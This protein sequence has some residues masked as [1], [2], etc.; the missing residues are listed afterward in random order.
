MLLAG[1]LIA[2][3]CD[4]GPPEFAVKAVAAG[5]PSL[6]PF[7]EEDGQLGED[8]TIASQPPHSGLQQGN[9]PGLYGG[10]GKP[11]ICDVERLKEFLTNP[12][13]DQKARE[14]ARIVGIKPARKDRIEEYL[15]GLTPVFLRHDT[16]VVNHD[17]KKGR[18]VAFDALLEAG[19]AVLV[20]DKGMPAVKCS[21]GN[22][23]RP[24]DKN[25]EHIAVEFD[26]GN[27]K[28]DGFDESDVVTVRPAPQTLDRV[29]LVD[30]HD[31][32]RGITRPVGSDGEQ[33]SSFDATEEHK[34]PSVTG[35]S[36]G[37]A[38]QKLAGLGLAVAYSGDELPPADA[39]VTGSEPGPGTELRFGEAVTL[40]VR[41]VGDGKPSRG[42]RT[43]PSPSEDSPAGSPTDSPT[44]EPT[45]REPTTREP[46]TSEPTTDE[47]TTSEPTSQEPTTS[48]PTTNRPTTTE[49]TTD[50]P[51]SAAPSTTEPSTTKPTTTEPTTTEPST[52]KPGTTEPTTTE[53]VTRE[54][55]P[56]EP[57]S[58]APVTKEP[59]PSEPASSAP[60]SSGDPPPE[61]AVQSPSPA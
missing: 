15:D 51:T 48:E 37:A 25:P 44:G 24:F 47:P 27:T 40:E 7:F 29:V 23:L 58:S 11:R 50:E 26:D 21:C 55:P 18:A 45:T 28:W 12:K 14:W 46:T 59:P 6:A 20:D 36:F 19:I 35:M 16:L 13:N 4:S 52:T 30:V 10:S 33:D 8:A 54:P 5:I 9:A 53:P 17:Y 38:G 3:G 32:D 56:G 31:P 57:A 41:S 39:R 61:E 22:P 60:G 49:P 34:V 43:G 1:V 2:S 42:S